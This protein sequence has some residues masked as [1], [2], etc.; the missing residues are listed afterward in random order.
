MVEAHLAHLF[1]SLYAVIGYMPPHQSATNHTAPMNGSGA[2]ATAALAQLPPPPP[3]SDPSQPVAISVVGVGLAA[4]LM[5]V[6]G[7]ISVW[8]RLGLHVKLAEATIRCAGKAGGG[9]R[10]GGDSFL[11]LLFVV[12]G[13]HTVRVWFWFGLGLYPQTSRQTPLPLHAYTTPTQPPTRAPGASSS[14][15]FSATSWSQS[16]WPT[17]GGSLAC[18]HSSCSLWRRL[19]RSRDLHR[20]TTACCY[21]C[22]RVPGVGGL[23]VCCGSPRVSL[24]ILDGERK[25]EHES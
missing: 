1:S 13:V 4:A 18:T 6:N 25:F 16:L 22:A 5:A 24:I 14:S 21:R 9:A 2:A 7:A 3:S 10:M 8:L 23:C 17:S 12:H 19:R 11:Y 15:P 20:P